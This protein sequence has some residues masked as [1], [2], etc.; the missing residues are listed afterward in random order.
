MRGEVPHYLGRVL[1]ADGNPCGTC[2]QV[3]N[4]LLVTAAHVVFVAGWSP[5]QSALQIEPLAAGV[6]GP[7]Y[8]TVVAVDRELDLA[9]LRTPSPLTG[10][11]SQVVAAETVAVGEAVIITGHAVVEESGRTTYRYLNAQGIWKGTTLMDGVPI[12]RLSSKA[13]CLV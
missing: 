11:L 1:A 12:G 8:A 5:E 9:V 4:G 10:S 13:S 6:G 2:F 7:V 3:I